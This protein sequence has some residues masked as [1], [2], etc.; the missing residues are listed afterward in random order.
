MFRHYVGEIKR[1]LQ[2]WIFEN[3][4]AF[5]HQRLYHGQLPRCIQDAYSACAVYFAKNAAN[6]GMTFRII[7]DKVG[8]LLQN[9]R[10][11]P[12]MS[13]LGVFEHLTHVQALLVYQIIRLF[14]GDIRQRALAEQQI[15]TLHRWT[16]DMWDCG[17]VSGSKIA[18]NSGAMVETHEDVD[19][20]WREWILAESVRRT[21]LAANIT[22]SVY[23]TLKQGWANCPGGVMFTA[24]TELWD[25]PSACRWA[26]ACREYNHFFLHSLQ[27]DK[28][29]TEARANEIGDFGRLI[30]VVTYGLGRVENWAG[31]IYEKP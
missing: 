28:L 12:S 22:Q 19:S 9:Q 7:E 16:K 2:L 27:A 13:M 8:Q 31:S 4:T 24:Q 14:D 18:L 3:K 11:E 30:L 21:W 1:W 25:A 15:P 6:E 26:K 5:I 29:F 20:T 10:A 23:L 17:L